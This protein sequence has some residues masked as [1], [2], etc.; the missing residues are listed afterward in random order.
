ML[1]PRHQE[2]I[3]KSILNSCG[4]FQNLIEVQYTIVEKI[5]DQGIIDYDF[6]TIYQYTNR[7]DNGLFDQYQAIVDS[8]YHS[9]YDH[10]AETWGIF[11]VQNVQCKPF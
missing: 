7:V 8:S 5:V 6:Q 1:A 9:A 4:Y 2:L 3:M 10:Q 11:V